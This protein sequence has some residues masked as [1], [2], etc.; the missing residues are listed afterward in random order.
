MQK[1]KDLEFKLIFRRSIQVSNFVRYPKKIKTLDSGFI[2][3]ILFLV[4]K[5]ILRKIVL[6]LNLL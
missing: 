3:I 6:F 1:I 5:N 2:G 4:V